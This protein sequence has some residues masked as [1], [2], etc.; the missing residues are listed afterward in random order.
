M[1]RRR[2]RWDLAF[3]GLGNNFALQGLRMSKLLKMLGFQCLKASVQHSTGSASDEKGTE[4]SC[5]TCIHGISSR[6]FVFLLLL[7]LCAWLS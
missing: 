5:G 1:H 2:G 6:F 3:G 7:S 4:S